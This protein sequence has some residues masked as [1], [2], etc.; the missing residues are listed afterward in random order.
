LRARPLHLVGFGEE[1]ETS[2]VIPGEAE[3][4]DPESIITNGTAISETGLMD[5]GSH[6][7]RSLGRNDGSESGGGPA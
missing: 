2:T 6:S 3:G 4:R 1:E 5:S 7:L